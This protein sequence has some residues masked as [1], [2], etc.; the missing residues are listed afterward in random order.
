MAA[1]LVAPSRQTNV[2]ERLRG[3]YV[4]PASTLRPLFVQAIGDPAGIGCRTQ[5][6]DKVERAGVDGPDGALALQQRRFEQAV[7][8]LVRE[9]DQ[10]G[11]EIE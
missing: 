4:A 3:F 2:C 10:G 11:C 9:L 7:V 5:R 1:L 8:R 6:H